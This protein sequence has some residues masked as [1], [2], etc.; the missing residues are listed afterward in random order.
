[1][2]A[3]TIASWDRKTKRW[4]KMIDGKR[5]K[6]SCRQLGLPIADHTKERSRN[7][8][9]EY[10][11]T[12]LVTLKLGQQEQLSSEAIAQ[13]DHLN[14]QIQ[15]SIAHRK[16]TDGLEQQKQS[17]LAN[18]ADSDN[19]DQND[20]SESISIAQQFGIEI[21]KDLDPDIAN[22][23]FGDRRLWQ[24]RLKD[25]EP[26]E[27]EFQLLSQAKKF[28]ALEKERI[29]K[30]LT[31]VD[32][33]NWIMRIISATRSVEGKT[34]VVLSPQM[35]TRKIDKQTVDDMYLWTKNH[36]TGSKVWGFFKRL[37][38][39][40]VERN[41]CELPP[42]LLSKQFRF[43][44]GKKKIRAYSKKEVIDC[45]NKV[46]PRLRLYALLALNT[47]MATVD[48]GHLVWFVNEDFHNNNNESLCWFD[49][50]KKTITRKRVKNED[51][52]NAPIITYPVWKETYKLLMEH[53]SDHESYVLTSKAN[54]KLWT[55]K[56]NLVSSQWSKAET[57]I[58]MHAFRTIG[59]SK[60]YEKKEY[61]P[62]VNAYL[63]NVPDNI[64]DS[65][66]A[67]I[68]QRAINGMVRWLGKQFDI[69]V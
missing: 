22:H 37:M 40:L 53:K 52:I 60:L 54:T 43:G 1:M 5:Y 69:D 64:R 24:E 66:Y 55:P 20:L 7:V 8:A 36:G 29:N 6:R 35:D 67:N 39:H 41:C 11:E 16:P 62:L 65:H 13:I 61:R 56:K 58:N 17:I 48:I 59:S 21:P 18:A 45:L 30:R 3:K 31:Y 47:S 2:P 15:W 12:L 19:W 4:E 38:M 27:R 51:R 32:L 25:S 28:L 68:P 42:N 23:F 9:N 49:Q 34:I 46:T 50:K 14:H 57:G 44:S 33:K 63:G 26:I 10:F